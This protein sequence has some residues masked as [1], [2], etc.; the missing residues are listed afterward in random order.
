MPFTARV[1]TVSDS[2]HAGKREDTSGP[3]VATRL[4]ELGFTVAGVE[5]V[6]D[7]SN[8]ITEAIGTAARQAQLV[9]TTG[10]TG[11]GPRD[12]T[13]EATASACE[14][15]VPGLAEAM[16]AAGSRQT[17]NA[18]LSRG[19]CGVCG[20]A[21]VINLPGSP[22]AAAQSLAA[23]EKLLPHALDLLQGKTEH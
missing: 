2:A 3:A 7:E 6:P 1:I 22:A 4:R 13:P 16:R 9:V 19:I 12:V 10:G 21:L 23:I 5:V 11:L 15:L 8:P 14:R 20:S 18:W 17:P